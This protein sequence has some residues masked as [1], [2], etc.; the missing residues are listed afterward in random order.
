MPSIVLTY[1]SSKEKS[2]N[3]FDAWKRP[4]QKTPTINSREAATSF[5]GC[6]PREIFWCNI[7]M[8]FYKVF[9]LHIVSGVF[10]KNHLIF[11]SFFYKAEVCFSSVIDVVDVN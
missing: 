5:I 9:D 3:L 7:Y 11:Q 6:G 4:C 10:S 1:S 2:L 8:Y